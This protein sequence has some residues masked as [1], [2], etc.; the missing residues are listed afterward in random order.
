M[1]TNLGMRTPRGE[2]VTVLQDITNPEFGRMILP[3]VREDIQIVVVE[4]AEMLTI[5]NWYHDNFAWVSPEG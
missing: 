5:V 4:P 3:G 2:I 1:I